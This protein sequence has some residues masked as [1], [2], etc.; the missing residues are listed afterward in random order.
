MAAPVRYLATL[1]VSVSLGLHWGVLQSVAWATM[2]ARQLQTQPVRVALQVTFD[3]RHPCGLCCFVRQARAA[4]K[5]APNVQ[6]QAP[7]L[8]LVLPSET[9]TVVRT[10]DAIPVKFAA[11]HPLFAR[12]DRP[13]LPPPRPS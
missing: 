9:R 8:E 11:V 6:T 5:H 13:A 3:G 7:R 2:L 4:Q 1:L 12:F 10:A